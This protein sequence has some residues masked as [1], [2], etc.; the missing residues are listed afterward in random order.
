MKEKGK[1]YIFNTPGTSLLR[2]KKIISVGSFCSQFKSSPVTHVK[3]LSILVFCSINRLGE[4]KPKQDYA[5][6][7][8]FQQHSLCRQ[9]YI[10]KTANSSVLH[11]A[12]DISTNSSSLK[13]NPTN[14]CTPKKDLSLNSKRTQFKTDHPNSFNHKK[15]QKEHTSS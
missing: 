9:Y 7:L 1:K 13:K 6:S 8:S 11:S 4:K 2:K 10:A 15:H 5:G 12:E 14:T 3:S